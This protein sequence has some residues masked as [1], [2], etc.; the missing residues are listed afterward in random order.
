MHSRRHLMIWLLIGGLL[1]A[2]AVVLGA[3]CLAATPV[4]TARGACCADEDAAG[5]AEVR[6]AEA[7]T[8]GRLCACLTAR[9]YGAGRDRGA[10]SPRMYALA[11]VVHQSAPAATA[12]GLVAPAAQSAAPARRA[13]IAA[14]RGPPLA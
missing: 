6:R 12:P 3:C 11:P 1:A 4:R 8:G 7:E 9:S 13:R 14:S 5:F 2:D 10:A